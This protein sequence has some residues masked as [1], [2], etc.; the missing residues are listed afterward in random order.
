MHF[1]LNIFVYLIKYS[2][3]LQKDAEIN[4]LKIEWKNDDYL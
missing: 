4:Q 1:P 3:T 2:S